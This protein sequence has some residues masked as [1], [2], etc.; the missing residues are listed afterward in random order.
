MKRSRGQIILAILEL[1]AAQDR[2][3]LAFKHNC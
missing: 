3:K 2:L 1:L